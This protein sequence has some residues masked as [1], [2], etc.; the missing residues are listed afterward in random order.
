MGDALQP[1]DLG[2]RAAIAIAAGDYHTCALLDDGSIRCWGD[3]AQGQ[4]G[5]GDVDDRSSALATVDLGVGRRA[6]SITAGSQ[7]T[8]AMLDDSSVKCWGDNGHGQLG[9]G[10]TV[11]RG[12][13]FNEMGDFLPP[14]NLGTGRTPASV[15]AGDLHTCAVLEDSS[16]KCWGYNYYGQLG[17]GHTFRRG[18][19]SD[20]MGDA[21]QTVSLW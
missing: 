4:L 20:D 21:L 18:G 10:D 9:L 16:V 6:I 3:N 1:V 14:I 11:S 2:A 17:I 7:H 12:D 8:C 13:E 19:E 5:L 15:T